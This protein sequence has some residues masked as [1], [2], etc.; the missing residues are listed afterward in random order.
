MGG[1]KMSR[2][3]MLSVEDLI[4]HAQEKG[5]RFN[6][7]SI[8]EAKD[9]LGKNNNYFKL[10]SYRKNYDKYIGGANA[11]KYIDLDFAYLIE[12]ARIDVEVRHILLKM[13]LDI[14]HFLKVALITEVEAN[15]G[16][17]SG[18]DGYQIVTNYV[19]DI[20]NAS[21]SERCARIGKR[22]SAINKKITQNK[23]N[24]YCGGLLDKYSDDMPIW[25][26]IELISFGDLKDLI[27]YY[28]EVTG[29]IPP[30]DLKSLDRVRQIRNAAAHNNC[31]IND[32][33]ASKDSINTPPFITNFVMAAGVKKDARTKRLSN[34]RVNQLVHLLY[35]YNKVVTSA[36]TRANR[37]SEL[38]DLLNTR[39]L[40]NQQY[41]TSNT[42]LCSVHRFFVKLVASL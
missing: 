10:C 40:K 6:I 21:F 9:Y 1:I 11:D 34:S 15:L 18:E 8:D 22:A 42:M 38:K 26:F 17:A 20:R 39:M 4:Q 5:I 36:N 13:C 14:E 32:L 24:P 31:I 28:S 12:L 35:V 7:L 27:Q 25:A 23:N 37:L 19:M 30:V 16:G 2:K 33:R 41:F 29:W 3:P